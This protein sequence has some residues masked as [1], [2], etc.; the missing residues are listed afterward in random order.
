MSGW[1]ML[2]KHC[3]KP[4]KKGFII[5]KVAKFGVFIEQWPSYRGFKLIFLSGAK[6]PLSVK[7][8]DGL[9]RETQNVHIVVTKRHV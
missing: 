7:S 4:F 3:Q 2:Q 9:T 1:K 5:R 6:L 8:Y